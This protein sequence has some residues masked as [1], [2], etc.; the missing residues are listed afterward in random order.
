MNS[1]IKRE[2]FELANKLNQ[3]NKIKNQE[4]VIYFYI[5][6]ADSESVKLCASKAR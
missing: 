6:E 5:D 3:A 4:T 1:L 2:Y